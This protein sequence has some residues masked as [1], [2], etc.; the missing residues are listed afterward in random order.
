MAS[1]YDIRPD[2]W[3][4]ATLEQWNNWHWQQQNRLRTLADLTDVIALTDSERRAF[5]ASAGTFRVAITPH[6]AALIDPEDPAC[7]VRQQAVPSPGEL[8]PRDFELDDP[9]AEDTHMPVPGITHRYPDRVLFY[10]SH[11]CPVYCRH[12]TRKRKVS[13]PTT[14]ASRAQIDGG[15]DYIRSTPEVRDVLISG[16]DP[17]T[18]SDARLAEIL[19]ELRRID[20]VEVIRLGTRNPVTLPQRI[21]DSLCELLR[22]AGPIYLHTHFN[23]P[24]ELCADAG[25][26]L[27]KL[28]RAGCVLGNQMV[29]LRGVNDDPQTVLELNRGLLRHGCRPYYM[30]QC[31]MARGITHFRT[32]LQ[33][34]LD[35]VE[36]LRGRIGGMGIPDFVV[37]LPGGGGKIE[38][39]PD[40]V[41]A[42]EPCEAGERIT[43]RNWAGEVFEFVDVLESAD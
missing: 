10:V 19:G 31:D 26:A 11:N 42:R 18:L 17:L 16:G 40:Y 15:L 8:A 6:Y 20:H 7:P 23:H 14:A 28:S 25:R 36:Y 27:E 5:E 4:C 21:T 32:P 22:E 24:R 9:L 13:D 3:A 2:R 34:G 33:T 1:T 30:L 37:D 38:L 29:L 12:C 39:S 35:I 41:I 43:F